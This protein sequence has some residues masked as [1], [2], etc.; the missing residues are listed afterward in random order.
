MIHLVIPSSFAMTRRTADH[1]SAHMGIRA[2]PRLPRL[3][4]LHPTPPLL[5]RLRHLPQKT[6]NPQTNLANARILLLAHHPP[7]PTR[8]PLRTPLLHP[9]PG[10]SARMGDPLAARPERTEGSH[11]GCGRL[12]RAGGRFEY[13]ASSVAV[14]EFGGAQGEEGDVVG[15]GG[16]GRY[17]A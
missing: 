15:G 5:P 11:G 16:V 14:C 9:P 8:R 2:L 13:C 6:H 12:V 1:E 17:G 7:A 4:P 10:K 3:P